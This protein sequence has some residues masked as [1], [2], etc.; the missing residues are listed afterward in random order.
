MDEIEILLERNSL[1]LERIAQIAAA[2]GIGDPYAAYFQSEARF[3]M[4]AHEEPEAG[5]ASLQELADRDRELY[6][7]LTEEKYGSSFG[8]PAYCQAVLPQCGQELCFLYAELKGLCGFLA[9]YRYYRGKNEEAERQSLWDVTILLELF[10]EVYSSFESGESGELP[11]G[12]QI[13]NILISYVEDYCHEMTRSRVKAL[14]DPELDFAAAIIRSSDLTD[15]R[16]LYRFG[17]PVSEDE[18]KLAEYLNTLPE[19]DIEAIARTFTRG[20]KDGFAAAR[21]DMSRKKSVAIRY[22]LGFERVIRSAI[23]QFGEMG[24]APVIYRHALHIADQSSGRAGFTGAVPSFQYEY[25]HRQDAALFLTQDYAARR[26]RALQNA[27]QEEKEKAE[28]FAGPAVMETFGEAPFYPRIQGEC[29]TY[30]EGQQ[31]LVQKLKADSTQITNRYSKP[32]ERS[33]TI[34]SFPLP[35]IGERF[36]EIFG[37]IVR[38]N[39]LD[40]QQ[41]RQIQQKLIDVLDTCEWVLVRGKD[42]NETDLIIH[43]HELRHPVRQTNFENCV[44]DV[45]IPVG[46]VFTSPVLA[47]TGGILHVKGVYL[48][49]LFFK[50]LRLVFDCGQVIDYSCGNFET[51]EENRKYIEDNILFHH[52]KIPMGE[53]A[54]GTNTTAYSMAKRLGI[55]GRLPILIAEKMG[56]HFALGD[57]CYAREE[58]VRIYNPDGKEVIARE[59]ELSALRGEDPELAYYNCHTDITLPYDELDSISVVDDDGEETYIIKNGRFAVPGTQ[60]LNLPLD[61]LKR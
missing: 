13:R 29:L 36:E 3:I 41:Y 27:Y 61:G 38:V 49:G 42:D 7:D 54:I 50:D 23:R 1:A 37:E 12:Q 20:F 28:W 26:L 43:L 31:K 14:L 16:Y 44:A 46:E 8:N 58:E 33:F 19:E 4:K 25:D 9:E 5:E 45:N 40:S 57:T 10:L 18:L 11:G 22:H 53:F 56:P 21:K 24:L 39:T 30:S 17:E 35:Q 32:S 2:P 60:E 52:V 55:E 47:G 6:Q 15:L 48:N 34:I 51:E 59:N